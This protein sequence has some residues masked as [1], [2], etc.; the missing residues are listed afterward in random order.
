MSIYNELLSKQSEIAL[1]INN[2]QTRP[3]SLSWT[4]KDNSLLLNLYS[5]LVYDVLIMN[6]TCV[7]RDKVLAHIRKHESS[8]VISTFIKNLC[9]LIVY[10]FYIGTNILVGNYEMLVLQGL[11]ILWRYSIEVLKELG[12]EPTK[13]DEGFVSFL[14]CI[15]NFIVNFTG[16]TIIASFLFKYLNK[17]EDFILRHFFREFDLKFFGMDFTKLKYNPDI[18]L[19]YL[20]TRLNYGFG[21]FIYYS[22]SWLADIC[23]AQEVKLY[24]INNLGWLLSFINRIKVVDI[25]N[26]IY[27]KTLKS[28]VSFAF[29]SIQNYITSLD[30]VRVAV[31]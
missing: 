14:L 19:T 30:P 12:M 6:L 22:I 21:P 13:L 7:C 23:N 29:K 18:H 10:M 8:D 16:S 3:D 17:S 20:Q 15:V 28:S 2:I 24:L 4:V 5:T 1:I 26:E 11:G 9:M 27:S 25:L 31:V